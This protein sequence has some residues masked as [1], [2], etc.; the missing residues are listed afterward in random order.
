MSAHRVKKW[1]P[2]IIRPRDVRIVT[3]LIQRYAPESSTKER[4][5]EERDRFMRLNNIEVFDDAVMPISG[6][7]Y[8]SGLLPSTI[9]CYIKHMLDGKRHQWG[10]NTRRILKA[11]RKYCAGMKA[12]KALEITYPEARRLISRIPQ[13]NTHAKEAI[14]LLLRTGLRFCDIQGLASD[15]IL[16]HPNYIAV[17]IRGGKAVHGQEGVR[18]A[19]FEHE[20]FFGPPSAHLQTLF[21]KV[22]QPF[23]NLSTES[24]NRTIRKATSDKQRAYTTYSFRRLVFQVAFK[25]CQWNEEL[26]ASRY[27][28]HKNPAMIRSF[29]DDLRADLMDSKQKI[30]KCSRFLA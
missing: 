27:T 21:L 6:Q 9:I 22:R 7:M 23:K 24:L 28:L 20:V 1:T 18:T 15:D 4:L 16:F 13:D 17:T 26:C 12:R 3:N 29:Y 11:W 30:F 25:E 2:S 5:R 10:V 8:K 14:E 19:R